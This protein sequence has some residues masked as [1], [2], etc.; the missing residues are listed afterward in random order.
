MAEDKQ[1][2]FERSTSKQQKSGYTREYSYNIDSESLQQ[3]GHVDS[4]GFSY[5][6]SHT[7]STQPTKQAADHQHPHKGTALAFT[8][9]PQNA[10]K[11]SELPYGRQNSVSRDAYSS[12]SKLE[13]LKY[14]NARTAQKGA[15]LDDEPK[16]SSTSDLRSK[17]PVRSKVTNTN[18]D[19]SSEISSTSHDSMVGEYAK[20]SLRQ[21][22]SAYITNNS[23]NNLKSKSPTSIYNKQVPVTQP[24]QSNIHT[25]GTSLSQSPK[26]AKSSHRE[27]DPHN[28]QRGLPDR[29]TAS[30]RESQKP[31]WDTD[32]TTNT[33]PRGRQPI[34]SA[35]E[36][37]EV[38]RKYTQLSRSRS[39][40]T[41]RMEEPRAATRQYSVTT[42]HTPKPISLLIQLPLLS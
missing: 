4:R 20:D 21:K 9:D 27:T 18:I 17:S 32:A 41:T 25:S 11:S 8:Y 35:S 12:N 29:P 34:L 23:A 6:R 5:E 13:E 22:T 10:S 40:S 28:S 15:R 26:S 38:D 7:T 33:S 16:L 36:I 42:V 24:F 30:K 37:E 31:L 3:P 1:T 19:E 39:S 14:G 2:F